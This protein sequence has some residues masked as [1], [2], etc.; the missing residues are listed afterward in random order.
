MSARAT[1]CKTMPSGLS[2]DFSAPT[3]EMISLDDIIHV[4]AR[5]NR[6]GGNIEPVSFSVAQHSL[7]AASACRLPVS[8]PYALLHDAAEAYIGDLPTPFKLWIAEAGAD[9][10]ALEHRILYDAIFPALGLE[11]PSSAI[12]ADV[13]DADQIALATEFRDVVKGRHPC[14]S[15]KAPPLRTRLKFKPTPAVEDEFRA[16]LLGALRPFG[17]VA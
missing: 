11:K 10:I 15:P 9:I 4:L 5:T 6:W 1:F 3:P 2:F 17:K 13:H 7:V 12:A 16:N 8:R 14:W